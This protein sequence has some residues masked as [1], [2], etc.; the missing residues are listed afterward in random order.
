[1]LK[2]SILMPT[3]K[4]VT[5]GTKW[6]ILKAKSENTNIIKRKSALE[7]KIIIYICSVVKLSA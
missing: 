6:F 4:E 3:Y 5:A 1:M 2:Q 7:S